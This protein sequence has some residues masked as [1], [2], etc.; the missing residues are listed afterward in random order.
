M[1]ELEVRYVVS[2]AVASMNKKK[3]WLELGV[4]LIS[5]LCM[6][7]YTSTTYTCALYRDIRV[8]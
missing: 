6:G 5:E 2:T 8:Q 4:P 3:Y 1:Y 7:T